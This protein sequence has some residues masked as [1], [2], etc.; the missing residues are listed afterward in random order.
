VAVLVNLIVV[1]CLLPSEKE[2]VLMQN[3]EVFAVL[4]KGLSLLTFYF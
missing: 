2:D 1:V 4:L 3:R